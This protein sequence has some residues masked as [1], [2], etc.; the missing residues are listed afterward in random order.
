MR[1]SEH[2]SVR[3]V[4]KSNTATRRGINNEPTDEHLKNL[5]L[6]AQKIFEPLRNHFGIAIGISSGY[7]SEELNKAVNG[8]KSSHHCSGMALDLDA[9]IY[10]RLTNKEIFEF[11]LNHL[12]FTQLIW[13]Y[14]TDNEPNWVHVAYDPNN[15]KKQVL[16]AVKGKGY[17]K[18]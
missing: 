4:S 6:V 3:E 1:L 10:G 9:D 2:L 8:S 5:K 17:I 16:R 12:E 7:R 14:G 13:E 18:F 11:I 15:L